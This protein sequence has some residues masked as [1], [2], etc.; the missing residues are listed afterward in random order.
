MKLI[1]EPI[2]DIISCKCGTA[3]QPETGDYLSFK[4]KDNNSF[5][6]EKIF[7]RCPTCDSCQKVNIVGKRD[8][9]SCEVKKGGAE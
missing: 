1:R 5:E 6:I 7:I 4:F 2:F 8:I 9:T 3:F